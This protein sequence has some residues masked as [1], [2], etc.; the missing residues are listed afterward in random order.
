MNKTEL[1]GG[2]IRACIPRGSIDVSDLRQVPDNQEV[3]LIE[4]NKRDL[5]IIFDIL[6]QPASDPQS[7]IE[8][9][10]ED[11]FDSKEHKPLK[12]IEHTTSSLPTYLVYVNKPD[13]GLVAFV[14]LFR[15]N[16]VQTD[17][18]ITLNI[19]SIL[20]QEAL[21]EYRPVFED[22]A[23]SFEVSDWSLFA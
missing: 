4:E 11:I 17:F 7:A 20:E 10:V 21:N 19:P 12:E 15:L 8:A 1:Y 13:I 18:L 22:I 2:A 6:E 9:H 23:R 16:Q 3:F 14:A 5:S